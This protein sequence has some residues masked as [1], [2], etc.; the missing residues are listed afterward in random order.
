MREKFKVLFSKAA[1]AVFVIGSLLAALWFYD[2]GDIQRG[3]FWL[4]FALFFQ[5]EKAAR[6]MRGYK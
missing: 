1:D 2:A 5:R 3:I 6:E 4:L